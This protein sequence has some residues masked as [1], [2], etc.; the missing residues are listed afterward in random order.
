[1]CYSKNILPSSKDHNSKGTQPHLLCYI[2]YHATNPEC[3]NVLAH[4]D[5]R[6]TLCQMKPKS[7]EKRKLV[8]K[9]LEKEA[10]VDVVKQMLIEGKLCY[11]ALCSH[12]GK[13]YTNHEIFLIFACTFYSFGTN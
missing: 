3:C 7:K 4:L 5:C 9:T 2:Y 12:S 13:R 8:L 11:G 6:S 10:I 1:M